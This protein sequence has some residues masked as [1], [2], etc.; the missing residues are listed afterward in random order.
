MAKLRFWT[1]FSWNRIDGSAGIGRALIEDAFGLAR[2]GGAEVMEVLANPYADG[3]YARLGF[4]RD[5]NR[6]HAARDRQQ[7]AAVFCSKL[8]RPGRG[9]LHPASRGLF[10][11]RAARSGTVAQR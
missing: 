1:V 8:D 9:N 6:D 7:N 3:F 4:V 10:V 2:A 5:R 11:Q